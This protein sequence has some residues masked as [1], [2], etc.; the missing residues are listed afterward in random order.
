MKVIACY[1]A[2]VKGFDMSTSAVI[3]EG[4]CQWAK[5]GVCENDEC[6]YFKIMEESSKED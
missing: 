6:P 5:D 2:I 1:E 3:I 4:V